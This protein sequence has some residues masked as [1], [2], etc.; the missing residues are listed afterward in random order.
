MPVF[1]VVLKTDLLPVEVPNDASIFQIFQYLK[2][3][4][5]TG[6]RILG[7]TLCDQ[8]KYYKLNNPVALPR[9]SYNRD[10]IVQT[11]M[12]R[13]NWEEVYLDYSLDVLAPISAR[14]VYIVIQPRADPT[15]TA[16][17][18]LGANHG[19]IF[20]CLQI[21]VA[22]LRRWTMEDVENNLQ[23]GRLWRS[24]DSPDYPVAIATIEQ[25]LA[26]RR[27]FNITV[28]NLQRWTM[29]DVENNLQ[30]GRLWRSVNLLDDDCPAA[31][32]T[33]EQSLARRRTFN[34]PPE[35]NS[36]LEHALEHDAPFWA[37]YEQTPNVVHNVTDREF[38]T[39]F[40]VVRCFDED[41][42]RI[43]NDGSSAMK[44]SNFISAGSSAMKASN[45]VVYFISP[46]FFS[47]FNERF[48]FK[49]YVGQLMWKFD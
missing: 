15:Q 28:A 27:T 47:S 20:G 21:T 18:D 37:I 49:Q 2:S 3:E 32:A 44:A 10:E 4:S 48:E 39:F 1:F 24:V 6:H 33:I 42:T 22:N 26:Q 8:Y 23:G 9:S 40:H 41:S 12:H 29:E 19:D 11:C 25:S 35:E 13:S 16:I 46:V 38:A 36:D 31:I 43:K 5:D 17:A 7:R 14:N 30:G 45:F 34:I